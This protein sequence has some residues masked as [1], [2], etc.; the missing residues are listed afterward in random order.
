MALNFNDLD[1][2]RPQ[3]VPRLRFIVEDFLIYTA[4]QGGTSPARKAWCET[5]LA[6]VNDLAEK[7]SHWCMS[8][9]TFKTSGTSITD[10]ELQARAQSVLANTPSVFMPA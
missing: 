10:A 6:N 8:E 3:L 5:N 1:T 9:A 4:G 2:L 7:L